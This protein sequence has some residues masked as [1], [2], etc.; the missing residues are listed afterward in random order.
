MNLWLI[1]VFPLVGSAINGVFGRRFSKQVVNLVAI[2]SVMLSFVWVLKT[3]AGLWPLEHPH[4][5]NYF[6]WIQSGTLQIGVDLMVD[7][8]TA[9]ML[10]IVTGV[11]LLIHT[12]AIGYMEH[13]EG[14]YRFFCYLLTSSSAGSGNN[15]SLYCR[16]L[17]GK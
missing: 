6:T 2:G 13:D 1:P 8:L 14:Y 4:I 3:L 12:Y 16:G 15:K 5:E 9:V 7:R 11:G 10:M 17:S